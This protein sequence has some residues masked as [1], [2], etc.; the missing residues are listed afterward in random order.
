MIDRLDDEINLASAT[1]PIIVPD[2]ARHPMKDIRKIKR[3]GLV[4]KHGGDEVREISD[5]LCAYLLERFDSLTACEEDRACIPAHVEVAFAPRAELAKRCELVIAV[6]GDGTLLQAGHICAEHD[7]PIIGINLGRLGFLVEI[8][9]RGF[10][11]KLD[12]I[13]AGKYRLE[14]RAM[15]DATHVRG[16]ECL[17][18][19]VA[20]N[21]VTVR[22][23]NPARMIELE[24]MIDGVFLNTVWSDGVIIATPTGSTAY[25]LS[26]GG[27]LLEPTIEATLL[28]PICPHTLSHR[29]LVV[30]SKETIEV[31]VPPS[32]TDKAVL[33]ID[34]QIRRDMEAG[35]QVVTRP[36][37][38]KLKLIQPLE[39]NYFGTLRTKLKWS[40]KL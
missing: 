6:G 35:D 24:T 34:G 3:L 4:L 17:E 26:S 23:K 16:G 19:F 11:E 12:A 22:N 30:N 5:R 37:A 39:H 15:L 10:G 31:T 28:V 1:S 2:N 27:P 36:L 32:E 33:A 29:P 25:A 8:P 40:E 13:W 7:V 38:H 9:P 18:R 21:D 14:E 20:C